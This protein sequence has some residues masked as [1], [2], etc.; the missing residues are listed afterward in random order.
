MYC[1]DSNVLINAFI[2]EQPDS[3]LAFNSLD[4]L[5]N[6][7]QK[8]V[9]LPSVATSFLRVVTN[10]RIINDSSPID[11]AAEFLDALLVSP[12]CDVME[13]GSSYW[14]IFRTL[15]AE[16]GPIVDDLPDIQIAAST[17]SLGATLLSFDRGFA[18]FSDLQWV[19][20]KDAK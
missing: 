20:P 13:P 17:I 16:H 9:I 2:A 11:E 10:R 5:R 6:G 1:V 4:S 8:V 14:R 3:S 7:P 12:Y 18:R 19:N 15:V